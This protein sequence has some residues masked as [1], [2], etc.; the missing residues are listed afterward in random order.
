MKSNINLRTL[1]GHMSGYSDKSEAEILGNSYSHH[2]KRNGD[3]ETAPRVDLSARR[4]SPTIRV[5][6][7]MA[8]SSA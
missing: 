7:A 2:D 3:V 1:P 4:H 5:G 8:D 6:G